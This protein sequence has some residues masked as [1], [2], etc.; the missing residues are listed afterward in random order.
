MQDSRLKNRKTNNR[1]IIHPD[2]Q[3]YHEPQPLKFFYKDCAI[4]I[5]WLLFIV[6]IICFVEYLFK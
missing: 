5:G 3:Y 2:N 4:L 1:G 6:A